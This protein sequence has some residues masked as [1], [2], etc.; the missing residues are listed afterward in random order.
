MRNAMDIG[1]G[2]VVT[3]DNSGGIGMKPDDIVTAPDRVT[4]YFATR[5][6][7]LEQWTAGAIPSSILV[8]NFSGPDSW[9]PYVKG[10]E[11]V[12]L[13]ADYEA[14]SISG[15]T[16]SN[17][18][19]LQSALAVTIIGK[20]I[21]EETTDELHWYIY[22]KPLVGHEVLEN[23]IQIASLHLI[24]QAMDKGLIQRIWPVGSGGIQSEYRELTGE[25]DC[26]IQAD[27][28]IYKSAGPA[29]SV[30]IGVNANRVE[31]AQNHFGGE[32]HKII[33]M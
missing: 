20:R 29:T 5:V 16:E 19:L 27:V 6:A 7:L 21:T 4:A 1:G 14:P 28:D 15:S 24:K 17:M 23:R 2:I 32:L 11:D 26:L 9:E 8:H 12:F 18:H 22:G 33:V 31:E 25:P 10:V 30:L 13:E 3:T